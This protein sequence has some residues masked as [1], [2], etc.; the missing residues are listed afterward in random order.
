MK[1]RMFMERNVTDAVDIEVVDMNHLKELARDHTKLW[2]LIAS[3]DAKTEEVVGEVL[4]TKFE[5]D[6]IEYTEDQL[7]MESEHDLG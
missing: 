1:A 3:Q 4:E 6:G 7:T 2:D 5:V